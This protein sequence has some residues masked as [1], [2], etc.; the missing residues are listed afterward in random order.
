MTSARIDAAQEQ[1]KTGNS[2]ALNLVFVLLLDFGMRH[3]AANAAAQFAGWQPTR[4]RP[5]ITATC[6][7]AA[8]QDLAA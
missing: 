7:R 6:G 8:A 3:P 1:G 4:S 5:R 2:G